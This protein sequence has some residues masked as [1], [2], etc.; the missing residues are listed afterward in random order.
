[1]NNLCICKDNKTCT[2]S[3]KKHCGCLIGLGCSCGETK[4]V[5]CCSGYPK[6]QWET[7]PPVPMIGDP[8]V[9]P[10]IPRRVDVR[11]TET[12]QF[13]NEKIIGDPIPDDPTN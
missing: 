6:I 1:M 5:D 11:Y 12:P 9:H 13:P 2:C 3:P 8:S 4:F 7:V 10:Q